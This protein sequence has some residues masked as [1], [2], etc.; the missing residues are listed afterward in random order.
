MAENP[1]PGP[2][3]TTRREE[4]ELA[5]FVD[6]RLDPRRA[7]AVEARVS[8]SAHLQRAVAM[9]RRAV[10]AVRGADV[11]APERLRA[12]VREL[13]GA[14][15]GRRRVQLGLAAALAGAAAAA[16]VVVALSL[17]GPAPGGP[18]TAQAA[19]LSLREPTGPPPSQSRARP[20][21]LEAS[22]AG[23]AYPYWEDR[24]GWRA[25]GARSDRLGRRLVNTVFY[26]R[27]DQRVGYS[28]VDGRRLP[29]PSDGADRVVGGVLLRSF[30]I[31]GQRAVTW[32]RDRRTCILSGRD[33]DVE[34][35]LVLAAERRGAPARS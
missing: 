10:A 29:P 12:R 21:V 3:P 9:Q 31:D 13:R 5:A 6:G 30:T 18:T 25:V 27:G 11:A 24:F 4:A 32:V 19:R 26:E 8:S 7:A 34:T 22:T 20:G 17:P 33:V 14:T 15:A 1:E 35:L 28:I 2:S 23:V 16:G